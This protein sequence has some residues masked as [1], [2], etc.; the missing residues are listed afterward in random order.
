MP[1]TL[2]H[3]AAV[4]PFMRQPVVPM[5]LVAGAMAPDLPYFAMVPPTYGGSYAALFNGISSHE[6]T[7]ILTVGMPLAL[8]LFGF[9]S[10]LEKPLGWAL[11]KSWL[12]DISALGVRPP[13]K[14]HVVLWTFH[15]LL[16]GL[17]THLVWDSFTH[18]SG[19][20]VQQFPLLTLEP[21]VGIPLF[22]LLQ[23]GSSL[24]GLAILA[25]WYRG[26]QRTSGTFGKVAVSKERKVRTMLLALV[27]VVPSAAAAGLGLGLGATPIVE[28]AASAE[29]FLQGMILRVGAALI[30]ALTVY[31]FAWHAAAMIRKVRTAATARA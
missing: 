30:V 10:F 12:P 14:A 29:L 6:F 2:A 13:T 4:L 24:A 9:L 27:L 8:V 21:V 5:A 17:L 3:A 19:W 26:R 23:H 20:V 15:S 22:R 28:D 25:L 18:S 11:P 31:G 16:L 1:F 7:H